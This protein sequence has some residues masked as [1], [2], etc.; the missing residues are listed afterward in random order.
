MPDI[1]KIWQ[2][3]IVTEKDHCQIGSV[4]LN[5]IKPVVYVKVFVVNILTYLTDLTHLHK[6]YVTAICF[7]LHF[8]YH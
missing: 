2:Y 5:L 7:Y 6:K 8:V 4:L 3:G 1:W